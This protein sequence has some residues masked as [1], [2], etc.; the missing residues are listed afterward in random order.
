M[1]EV[2][3]RRR[4]HEK[5]WIFGAGRYGQRV[6]EEQ[7][8]ENVKGFIDNNKSLWNTTIKGK[9]IISLDEYKEKG[10][11]NLIVVAVMKQYNQIKIISQLLEEN[12]TNYEFFGKKLLCRIKRNNEYLFSW[13][14]KEFKDSLCVGGV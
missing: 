2:A 1:H 6:L 4:K 13:N 11:D 3:H 8:A 5:F 9:T 14:G 10:Y 12:I 7:K